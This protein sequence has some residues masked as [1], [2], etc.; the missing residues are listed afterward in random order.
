MISEPQNRF[1]QPAIVVQSLFL[2][3]Q[4]LDHLTRFIQAGNE[5]LGLHLKPAQTTNDR[6][7]DFRNATVSLVTSSDQRV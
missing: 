3:K 2:D 4:L 1:V 5:T 6:R 7:H